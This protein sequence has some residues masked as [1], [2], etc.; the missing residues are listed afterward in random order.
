L[1]KKVSKVIDTFGEI[2]RYIVLLFIIAP[3]ATVI[4]I[5]FT[6]GNS[7]ELPPVG[8]GLKWYYILVND[9][10]FKSGVLVSIPLGI[11]A[12][13]SSLVIGLCISYAFVK[14][15]LPGKNAL[16]SYVLAPIIIPETSIGLGLLEFFRV[17]GLFG[18]F[19]SLVLA[20]VIITLPYSIRITQAS[21][22]SL[23]SSTEEAAR[24]LGANG[25]ETF[26]HITMPLIRAALIASLLFAFAISIDDVA[27]TAFLTTPTLYTM[28]I[29][30]L[31][32]ASYNISPEL[33]AA[34]GVLTVVTFGFLF[35]IDKI[36]GIDKAMSLLAYN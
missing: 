29:V 24:I 3:I 32:W 34:A 28:S 21:F 2:I 31:G 27:M 1:S 18:S 25:F 15:R 6:N 33:A 13:L 5:S 12:S 8:L 30:M 7:I 26:R 16:R 9:A 35:L 10:A 22:L 17:V 36:V 4:V 14:F 19:A 20:H 11:I 23:D